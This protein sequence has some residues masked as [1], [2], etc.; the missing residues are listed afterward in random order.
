M[1]REIDKKATSY[2]WLRRGGEREWRK[3][4]S[5]SRAGWMMR[6]EGRIP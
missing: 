1:K 2:L 4:P 5:L 3:T 6:G